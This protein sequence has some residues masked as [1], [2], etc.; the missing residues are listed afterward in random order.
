MES[1]GVR[2]QHQAVYVKATN[3]Y[4]YVTFFLYISCAPFQKNAA[5]PF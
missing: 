2:S 1:G 5:K 4:M 3:S